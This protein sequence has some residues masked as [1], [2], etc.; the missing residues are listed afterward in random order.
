MVEKRVIPVLLLDARGLVKTVGFGKRRYIGDP[1]NAVKLF[2]EKEVDEL[3]L[4]DID[5]TTEKHAPRF[6]YL[7][8]IVSEA[9]M[10]VSYGGGVQ[11]VE[12]VS[13]LLRIGVE[14]VI[15]NT[16]LQTHPGLLKQLTQKFG[17]TTII[18]GI[19][20]KKNLLGKW[21]AYSHGGTK[22]IITPLAE[23]C[24]QYE[25]E[26][27]GELLLQSI[28]A[29]GKM[30]GYDDDLLIELAA[31]VN[32]PVI[33]CGGAGRLQHMARLAA[34]SQV[35]AFGAG[36]MFIYQGPH[37]AVLINYPSPVSIQQAF[38]RNA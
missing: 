7:E 2:N 26:G 3:V 23:L 12:Q 19:D 17:S 25:A 10:P 32:I 11:S 4:L 1:I 36:S 5:A 6:E 9:F 18:A 28:G 8:R 16:A 20:F 14:K 13:S 15:V 38:L 29:D 21:K 31:Q 35:A 27:A 34:R 22:L 30:T 37:R 24:K 33:A